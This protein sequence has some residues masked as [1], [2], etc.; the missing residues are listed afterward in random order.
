M[1]G[2]DL[3]RREMLRIMATA[4]AASKFPGFSK[5]AFICSQDASAVERIRTK[6]NS[7]N[8][9]DQHHGVHFAFLRAP[10]RKV[11]PRRPQARLSIG[12]PF[13]PIHQVQSLFA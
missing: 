11:P 7:Q 2:Q 6:K 4:A 9:H 12:H 3:Q 10:A 1:A 13:G 5:W 8:H